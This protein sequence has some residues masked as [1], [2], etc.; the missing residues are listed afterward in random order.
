M[1]LAIMQPYFF[2]YIGY[3]QLINAVD[4]FVL[5][6]DVNY[7]KKGWINRNRILVSNMEYLFTIPVKDASQNKRINEIFL[8][9]EDIWKTKLL[10][11]LEASYKKAPFYNVTISMIKNLINSNEKNLSKYIFNSLE[12]LNSYLGITTKIISSTSVYKNSCLKGQNR[13][14]DICRK[15]NTD[16]YINAI[17]G[18]SLY[19]RDEFVKDGFELRFIRPRKVE[20]PQYDGQF[21]P[22]LS[23]ID[24]IMFNSKENIKT[25]LNQFETL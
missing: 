5:L 22:W 1:K 23:I 9:E 15:E 20:Y 19:S 8:V 17:G 7:I 10:K 2:P 18:M 6:D 16:V 13:I 24:V 12:Q 4:K 14:I 25:I 21:I 11:T 3:F